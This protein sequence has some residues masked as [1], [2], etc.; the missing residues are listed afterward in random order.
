LAGREKN[1][2]ELIKFEKA[3]E[4]AISDQQEQVDGEILPDV[5]ENQDRKNPYNGNEDPSYGVK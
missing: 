5:Y 3:L 2:Y 1:L 4:L